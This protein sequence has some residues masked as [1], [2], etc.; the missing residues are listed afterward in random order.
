MCSGQGD[1]VF[2]R[3]VSPFGHRRFAACTRLPDAFRSVP[4]PSSALDAQASPVRPLSLVFLSCGD[5]AL[6]ASPAPPRP[7][8]LVGD[9]RVAGPLPGRLSGHP[10]TRHP[11]LLLPRV[12]PTS[13][14]GK[15]TAGAG[16]SPR[17]PCPS[18]ALVGAGPAAA[19]FRCTFSTIQFLKYRRISCH[20][21]GVSGDFPCSP[22]GP[23]WT[24]TT[25]L[26][27]IRGML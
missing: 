23:A 6:S 24:R 25:D 13:R 4:R 7:G 14:C 19:F 17:L 18:P 21:P 27:L 12:A 20:T 3:R 1:D 5:T 11:V 10:A 26:S 2:H 16:A 9:H 15:L 22:C 8:A